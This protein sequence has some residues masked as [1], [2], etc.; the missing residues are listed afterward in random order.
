MANENQKTVN[1]PSGKRKGN[2][3][4]IIVGLIII[5]ALVGVGIWWFIKQSE[6]ITTDD[7]FVD[8]Y[9]VNISSQ[10]P[11]RIVKL[12]I[13]EG[14]Y[15]NAG[16][17]IAQLDSSTYIAQIQQ[18]K[19]S[20]EDAQI[21]IEMAKVKLSQAKINYDRAKAQY[22]AKLI[23]KAN[24]QN[25]EKNYELAQVSVKVAQSK[26]PTIKASL[27]TLETALSHTNIYAPMDGIAAKRWVLSGDVVSPGQSMFTVFGTKKI[28]VTTMLPENELRFIHVGD[29]AEITVDAFPTATFKG[30]FYQMGNTT[31]SKFSLIPPNNASG[32][33][34]KVTQR[35]P[36][37]LTIFKTGG[38]PKGNVALLPGMS[39]ELKVKIKKNK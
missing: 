38:T 10:I 35:V 34:T 25:M 32:N 16:E 27:N 9:E 18:A 6:F 30:V 24:Y 13:H 22:K 37:K 17:L 20:L 29:T 1:E 19:V 12:Y 21:G 4:K 26:I 36:L 31:A 5:A 7:A 8:A 23:P 28:W 39:V 14:D 15:V 11:G 3:A 2:I 33:F